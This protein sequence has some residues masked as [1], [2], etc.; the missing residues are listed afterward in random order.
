M[1]LRLQVVDEEGVWLRVFTHLGH[2]WVEIYYCLFVG[3]HKWVHNYNKSN[4]PCQVR[5][6]FRINEN[7]RM[8]RLKEISLIVHWVSSNECLIYGL[9][10]LSIAKIK[11][12]SYLWLL[13][14][15]AR[16]WGSGCWSAYSIIFLFLAIPSFS[17]K[18]NG[19]WAMCKIP[20]KEVNSIHFMFPNKLV[21]L[22]FNGRVGQFQ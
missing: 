3:F 13:Y 7:D 6:D 1:G 12:N 11:K 19:E 22:A 14:Y 15:W 4:L 20:K 10:L 17:N 18:M 8:A 21:S 5:P 9:N 2:D 16:V